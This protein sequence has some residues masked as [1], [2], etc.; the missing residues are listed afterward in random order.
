MKKHYTLT[1]MALFLAMGTNSCSNVDSGTIATITTTVV[2][3]GVGAAVGGKNRE[4]AMVIG[5]LT[6]ALVG[7]LAAKVWESSRV[8]PRTEYDDANQ[9]IK[10]NNKQLD[11]RLKTAK[12]ANRDLA[13]RD[14]SNITAA[15]LAT[16]KKANKANTKLINE[17]IATAKLAMKEA[18]P[19]QKQE[20]KTKVSA[21][22]KER[23]D[24]ASQI[25]ALRS[26]KA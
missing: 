15:E 26:T 8:K 18:N 1:A 24:M 12:K 19:E 17:D 3:I 14:T 6:G 22:E 21:L 16:I 4:A 20:L 7:C 23:S 13:N 11:S 5:G 9:Y 25:K 10:A 2:G